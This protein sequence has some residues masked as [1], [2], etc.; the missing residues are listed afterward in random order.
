MTAAKSLDAIAKS[1][2][3]AGKRDERYY[4]AQLFAI[5]GI[6]GMGTDWRG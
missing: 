3:E 5:M 4:R 1:L 6:P 2:D